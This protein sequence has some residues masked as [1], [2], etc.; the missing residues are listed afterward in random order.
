MANH[1]GKIKSGMAGGHCGR[2]RWKKT[3]VL[4]DDSKKARQQEGRS[5]SVEELADAKPTAC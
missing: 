5:Q 4:K 2:G 1:A 3:A